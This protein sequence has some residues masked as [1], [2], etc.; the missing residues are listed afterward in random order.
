[1]WNTAITTG[2]EH[3]KT[4]RHRDFL[5]RRIFDPNTMPALQPV[6]F[7]SMLEPPNRIF[8]SPDEKWMLF[9]RNPYERSELMLVEGFR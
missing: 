4:P 8:T 9:S 3:G 6:S 2:V 7:A 1:M 5:S